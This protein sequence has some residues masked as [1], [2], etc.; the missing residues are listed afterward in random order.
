MVGVLMG[1]L[2]G[3]WIPRPLN[4]VQFIQAMFDRQKVHL[5]LSFVKVFEN[6]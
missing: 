5:K 2:P 6:L 4:Y 3:C 1:S